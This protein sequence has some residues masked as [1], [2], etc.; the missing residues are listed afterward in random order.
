[1]SV[2]AGRQEFEESLTRKALGDEAFRAKLL[3][4]PDAT[5]RAEIGF[6][7]PE[8]VDI[9]VIE[10]PEQSLYIVLPPPVKA[11]KELSDRDLDVAAGG[12]G[13][14]F[15]CT[16]WGTTCSIPAFYCC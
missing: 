15:W 13:G 4:D 3:A 9:K 2:L 14:S 1:M 12:S 16:G 7:L 11:G 6:D 5:I 10:E 8:N